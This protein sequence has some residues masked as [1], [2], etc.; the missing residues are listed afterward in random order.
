MR[1]KNGIEKSQWLFVKG[2]MVMLTSRSF[3]FK[4]ADVNTFFSGDTCTFIPPTY[5]F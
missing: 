4:S 3:F 5:L 2:T 1:I